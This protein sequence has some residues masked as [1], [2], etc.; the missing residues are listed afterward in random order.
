MSSEKQTALVSVR[1]RR[2]QVIE[3][4]SEQFASDAMNV[5]QLEAR[6]DRAHQA[7]TIEALDAVVNDFAPAVSSSQAL[8]V[9]PAPEVALAPSTRPPKKKRML[10]IFGGFERR[11]RWRVPQ[12][13]RVITVMGG[14]N[15]DFR[16]AEL[17]PGETHMHITSV[18]GGVNIIVPPG[19][20]VECDGTAIM[21]GFEMVDRAPRDPDPERPLLRITGLAV[22]GGLNIETRV[23]RGDPARKELR[24]A[25]GGE[26][27]AL[28]EARAKQLD[29]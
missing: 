24:P 12:K 16:D 29:S 25:A 15:F 9:E 7:T 23:S 10:A 8:A 21:G 5:E 1:E 28:P 4:L 26:R 20:A 6:L 22:M 13:I 11:G 27:P 14:A 19:L 3:L 2:D 17:L 18:M